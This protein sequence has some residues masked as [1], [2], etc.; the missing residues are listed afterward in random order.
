MEGTPHAGEQRPPTEPKP[1]PPRPQPSRKS[2]GN[3]RAKNSQQPCPSIP[4]DLK[5]KAPIEFELIGL[6]ASHEHYPRDLKTIKVTLS[7]P[8]PDEECPVALEPIST[9]SLSF[10]PDCPFIKDT[11][12]YSKMT[13]PCGHSFAAMVIVYN[14]CK[15]NML[16]PCCRQGHACRANVNYLPTHFRDQLKAHVNRSLQT[17]RI[18]DERDQIHAILNISPIT[19]S[20]ETLANEGSLELVVG[21]NYR[22][23]NDP[24]LM[25]G[26]LFSPSNQRPTSS[27]GHFSMVVRLGTVHTSRNNRIRSIFSPSHQNMA[28]LRQSPA[29]IR[30]ISITTQMR[31]L[32]AGIIDIDN[33]GEIDIPSPIPSAVEL[34]RTPLIIRRATGYRASIAGPSD[35]TLPIVPVSTFEIVFGQRG[36]HVFLNNVTWVPDSTHVHVSLNRM[37]NEL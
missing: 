33:S 16:C 8:L 24:P 3:K 13:L 22:I 27:R 10:L 19:M 35:G 37:P 2:N 32:D 34:S 15:N 31:V 20:F 4:V 26:D 11:P 23:A 9:A 36:D 21:F 5:S 17:E 30:S 18:D 28:V 6:L 7:I 1:D 12:E 29:D 25:N 14:W